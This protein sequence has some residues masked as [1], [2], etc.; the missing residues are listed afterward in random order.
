LE[1][2]YQLP[3]IG[4]LLYCQNRGIVGTGT[5]NQ[6]ALLFEVIYNRQETPTGFWVLFILFF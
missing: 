4:T 2:L 5:L 1:I 6:E 3:F